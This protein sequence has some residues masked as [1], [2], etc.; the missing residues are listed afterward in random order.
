MGNCFSHRNDADDDDDDPAQLGHLPSVKELDASA[1]GQVSPNDVNFQKPLPS[2]PPPPTPKQNDMVV[3][4]LY[5][6]HGVNDD[7]LVFLKGDRMRV[8]E[9]T[10]DLDWWLATHLKT[11]ATGYIPSNYVC[12]DDNSPQAQD[13]WFKCERK[14]AELM[15]LLPGNRQGT[16]LVREAHDGSALVLSVRFDD[17]QT[18]DPSVK[19][20]KMKHMDSGGYFISPR[21]SFGT[22]LELV[23]HFS[24]ET[25]GLCTRLTEPCPR[26]KPVTKFRD[27][28]I[29]RKLI[30]LN[31]KL[32]E[33]HFGA[34]WK[35]KLRNAA[36]V[37][38][39]TLK[40]GTMSP[41]AF[42][43][44]ARIMHQLQ[45]K[46]LVHLLAVC[47]SS[48]PIWI[49]TEL[50]AKGSLLDYLRKDEGKLVKFPVMIKIAAQITDG[51][52]YLEYKEFIHR[53][54]RAA[55][56]LVG[57]HHDVKVAD[58][59]LAR[60]LEEG[61][62]N[63]SEHAQF[64]IKWTAPEAVAR[65]KF[66][67]KSDVWSFGVLLYEVITHGR[68]PYPGV[69]NSEVLGR[70][71][72]GY[73]MP[74]PANT[75]VNCPN[76]LYEIMLKCWHQ[77]PHQRPTFEYLQSMFDDFAINIESNYAENLQ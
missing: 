10:L 71:E 60:V 11:G 73:R 20:Y 53:D 70:L 22:L 49:V 57:E 42:L 48:E 41:D 30:S 4:A 62:Y 40:P 3:R 16:F 18:G 2:F 35:G 51:M 59:G 17:P 63:A 9:S 77:N 34:V 76:E 44:E 67:I 12:V 31:M 8:D 27:L 6:F 46:K 19:H 25:D 58:F 24:T 38:V 55:N 39:K 52:A 74:K 7:D 65:R 69:D 72:T 28:E 61:T 64:P 21:N 37:A 54:L 23:E 36:D 32:G 75:R 68:V 47:S 43:E 33:G 1:S 26:I 15:L 66:S 56:V 50:M 29:D 45:H 14:E 5:D 13:W